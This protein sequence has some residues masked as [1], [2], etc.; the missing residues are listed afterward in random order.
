MKMTIKRYHENYNGNVWKWKG[1]WREIMQIVFL[2][3]IDKCIHNFTLVATTTP[4]YNNTVH[5]RSTAEMRSR[6]VD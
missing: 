1:H 2:V 5:E 3:V 4:T 6:G